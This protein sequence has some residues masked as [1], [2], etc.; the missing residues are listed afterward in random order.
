M[1]ILFIIIGLVFLFFGGEG[2]VKGAVD[3]AERFGLST[4][5]VSLI[6]VGFGTSAPE[7]FVCVQAAMAGA[8]QMAL[9]NVVGSNLANTLLI[10]GAS[11]VI[12]PIVCNQP[13]MRRDA[14]AVI[15]ASLLFV[16]LTIFFDVLD[17]RGGALMVLALAAYLAMAYELEKRETALEHAAR[18]DI[19]DHM[20]EDVADDDHGHAPLFKSIAYTLGGLFVLVLGAQLLVDGASSIAR[21]FGV[22]EAVIGLSLVALG[23]S[24]PEL[25]TAVVASMRGHSDVI[26]GNV[27]GSNLFNIL[28][29][30]GFTAIAEPLALSGRIT[31]IDMWLMLGSALILYPIMRS[32]HTISR[33]EGS[34]LLALYGGYIA[35]MFLF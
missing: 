32:D 16:T 30:L 4:L 10:L 1:D 23:T 35:F 25:A 7:L 18:E 17:W 26:I 5:L 14:I 20:V 27:L 11:A 3:I 29:I 9:G 6:I 19:K 28:S 12:T 8:P 31:E 13:V 33:L 15:V 24:L 2:L 21:T 22:S 34:V